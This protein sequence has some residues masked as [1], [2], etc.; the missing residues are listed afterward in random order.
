M[1]LFG[2]E[3]GVIALG[4]VL[5]LGVIGFAVANS[6]SNKRRQR[7]RER[8]TTFNPMD[9]IDSLDPDTMEGA[10]KRTQG[11]TSAEGAS[12]PG[13][14][15]GDFGDDEPLAATERRQS[16]QDLHDQQMQDEPARSS[17]GASGT[18]TA[19]TGQIVVLYVM[20]RGS[21]EF[22]VSGVNRVLTR[23]ECVL[24]ERGVFSLKDEER[25]V[26]FSVV[27]ALEPATFDAS[28]MDISSTRGVAFFFEAKGHGDKRR[29][30]VMLSVARK[31]AI[32]IEGEL[33]DDKRE[34]L[35]S[36]REATLRS[37]LTD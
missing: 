31:L 16:Q 13:G 30:D 25:Q 8:N 28:S 17:S 36:V 21:G 7:A 26:V 4:L 1:E 27:N 37:D 23:S 18:S 14:L 35:S 34:P 9:F 11:R 32:E 6:R 10:A 5:I 29:L 33:L 24:D 12:A 20:A 3:I 22:R 2:F 19:R 15:F